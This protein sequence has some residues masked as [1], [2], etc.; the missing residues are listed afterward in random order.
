MVNDYFFLDLQHMTS[1][2]LFLFRT[3]HQWRISLDTVKKDEIKRIM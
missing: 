2:M 1:S 3:D